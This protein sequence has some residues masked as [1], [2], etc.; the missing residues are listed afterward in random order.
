M[1]TF[2]RA[3]LGGLILFFYQFLSFAGANFHGNAQA[4]TEKQDTIMAFLLDNKQYILPRPSEN[5]TPEDQQKYAVESQGKP[6][7]MVNY[8]TTKDTGMIMPMV[9]GL[10]VDILAIFLVFGLLDKIADINTM[11]AIIYLCTVGFFAFLVVPYTN[12]IWYQTPDIWAHLLD[13]FV[14]Y[15]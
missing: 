8:H 1:K 14:P 7:A 5:A 10:L 11:K 13:A 2:Y 6:W 15:A 9:R 4:Y 12:Y 3:L